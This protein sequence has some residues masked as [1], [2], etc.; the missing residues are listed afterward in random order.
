MLNRALTLDSLLS[1]LLSYALGTHFFFGSVSVVNA[2]GITYFY[3]LPRQIRIIIV[4]AQLDLFVWAFS[5]VI[6]SV[7]LVWDSR[8]RTTL[9][10]HVGLGSLAIVLALLLPF[11]PQSGLVYVVFAV[12][13]S[14]FLC[15]L[16]LREPSFGESP[17]MLFL[18]TGIILLA[19]FAVVEIGSGVHYAVRSFDAHTQIGQF[20]ASIEQQLSYSTYGLIPWLYLG[21]LLSWLW[22]PLVRKLATRGRGE[23]VLPSISAVENEPESTIALRERLG[24]MLNPIVILALVVA[25]FMGYYA[26][27]QNPPWLVGTDAYWRYYNPLGLMNAKGVVGG[28]LQA[29]G[30]RHPVPLAMMYAVQLAFRTSA[31]EVVRATPSFLVA[32]LALSS[33]WFL[34]KR[35]RIDFGVLVFLFSVFSV[36]TT[37]GLFAS[38]LANWMALIVWVLFYAYC[39]F[40]VDSKLRVVDV[41]VLLALSTMILFLHPWTWGVFAASVFLVGLLTLVGDGRR[42]LRVAGSLISVILADAVLALLSITLLSSS[43]GWRVANSIDLYTRSIRDPGSLL[44]FW[45]ALTRLVEV[46]SPF[47]S[48]LILAVSIVGVFALLNGRL[49]SIRKRLVLAW[50]FVSAVG[51]VLVAPIGFFTSGESQLWRVFFLTPFWLTV[52]FGAEYLTR[53]PYSIRIPSLADEGDAGVIGGFGWLWLGSLFVIGVVLAWLPLTRGLMILL[54]VP[55]VTAFLLYKAGSRERWFL[56]SVVLLII[57]LVAFNSTTR[58]IAQLLLSPHNYS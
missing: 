50:I 43:E 44:V 55:L 41:F 32:A 29:L 40:R 10:L 13:S 27:F 51:S 31:F 28:F 19:Y 5:I 21:F 22:I 20:E 6:L 54:I 48:S 35:K 58:G 49:S 1:R 56:R 47:F 52:P 7:L 30:E 9:A 37:V 53:L 14:E 38:I 23:P 24:T 4:D 36:T 45:S 11:L 18:R 46:W 26:Y 15:Q 2:L 17:I 33:W 34:A 25:F 39:S 8:R 57:V 16:L 42:G 3:Y 12:A